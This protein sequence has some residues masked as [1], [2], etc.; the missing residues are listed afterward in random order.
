MNSEG[1]EYSDHYHILINACGVLNNYK[2]PVID[3][4]STFK[5]DTIHSAAWPSTLVD[6]AGKRVGLIGNG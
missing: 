4:L 5:G 3:G 1:V 2:W 6:L